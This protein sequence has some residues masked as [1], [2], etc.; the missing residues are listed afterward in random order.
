MT[1]SIAGTSA[2][3]IVISATQLRGPTGEGQVNTLIVLDRISGR[4]AATSGIAIFTGDGATIA[5]VPFDSGSFSYP[6]DTPSVV[7]NVALSVS[8]S[9]GIFN[10]EFHRK[11]SNVG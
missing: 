11:G 5:Q 6:V 10:I 2:T 1:G 9:A 8:S 7:S 3:A 4:G